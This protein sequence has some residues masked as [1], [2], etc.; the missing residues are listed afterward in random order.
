MAVSL[1]DAEWRVLPS[2]A[3]VRAGLFVGTELD[4]PKARELARELRRGRALSHAARA[5][6]RRDLSE[7]ELDARL[8]RAGFTPDARSS[9][10][11]LLARAGILDDGRFARSRARQL[12]ERGHGDGAIRW[13]LEQRGVAAEQVEHA[14]LA[15]EPERARAERLVAERGRGPATARLLAR[16]GFSEDVV[17]FTADLG[18]GYED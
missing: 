16:R 4:R 15:V 17:A 11:E 18:V 14:L 2:D 9:A 1:D 10:S 6:G 12:A 7:Q 13:D 5:L 8:R 3:V